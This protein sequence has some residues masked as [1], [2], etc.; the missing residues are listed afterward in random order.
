LLIVASV[1]PDTEAQKQQTPPCR[2]GRQLGP[3]P[4]RGLWRK[5]FGLKKE[6]KLYGYYNHLAGHIREAVKAKSVIS[7]VDCICW[8]P[9]QRPNSVVLFHELCESS[10]GAELPMSFVKTIPRY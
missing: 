10:T 9:K 1:S 3:P 5:Q 7:D 2:A 8:T 6:R 4:W